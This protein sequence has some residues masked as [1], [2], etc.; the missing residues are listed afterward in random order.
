MAK[1]TSIV[2]LYIHIVII[3]L[4]SHSA[5]IKAT[6]ESS[7][8]FPP[9]SI[10]CKVWNHTNMDCSWRELDCIPLVRHKAS[11]K[12]LDM[13]HN[14]LTVLPEGAFSGFIKLKTLDLSSNGISVKNGMFIGLNMLQTLDM[15]HNF[16]EYIPDDAFS[17]LDMLQTLDVSHN[18]LQSLP[19]NVFSGLPN[20]L[21]LYLSNMDLHS[22]NNRTFNGLGKLETLDLSSGRGLV[23]YD[24]P[25]QYLSS[26]HT[27]SLCADNPWES[28]V[29]P[30]TFAGLNHTLQ[31][32]SIR[33]VDSTSD[34]PFVQ[35]SSLQ[36]LELVVTT[37]AVPEELFS[38]LDKLRHLELTMTIVFDLNSIFDF[39]PLVSLTF[40]SCHFL[41][42]SQRVLND[43]FIQPL[44]LSNSPLQTLELHIFTLA[45]VRFRFNST[46]FESLPKWKESLREL[47]IYF[48]D[49]FTD[50]QIEGSPF[51]WFSQLH[52]LRMCGDKPDVATISWHSPEDTFKGL[53]NLKEV[54]LNY[55]HIDDEL[56]DAVLSTFVMY[57]NSLEVLDLAHNYIQMLGYIVDKIS[58]I[59][60]LKAIDISHNIHRGI[61]VRPG[62]FGSFCAYNSNLSTLN[63]NNF[64]WWSDRSPFTCSSLVSLN[65]SNSVATIYN[66]G[67]VIHAPHLEELHLSGIQITTF[68][69]HKSLSAIKV[70]KF[71]DVPQLKTLDLSSSQLLIIDK[72][73][74]WRLSNV[75]YLDLRNNLLTTLS[76]LYHL[77]NVE[78]LLLSGNQ[79]P[80]VP[81]S[82]LSES[83]LQILDLQDNVFT[84]DC[85]IEGLQ[86]WVLTDDLTYLW[87]IFSKGHRYKC[88]V[89]QKSMG[90]SLTEVDLGYCDVPLFMYISVGVTSGLV[91]IIAAILVVWYRWHIQYRLFLLFNRRAYQNY[92]VNGDDADDDFE[93]EDGPP[94]Y[95]AYVIYNN[96]DEDW[97]DEQLVA[98]IE[99]N[100]EEPFRLCLKN[101]DI[102]A[103]RLI[104]NELSLHI[105]R[106]R[107]TLVILTPR[108]VD[109]NWCYF[110]LNMAHHRVL[111]E[112][113]NVLIFIM[114][115]KIPNNRLT[116]LLRQLF[117]RAQCLKWPNDERGQNLFWRCLREELKRP[118]PRDNQVIQYRQYN[119]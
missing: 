97:V 48:E 67:F 36:H 32:L 19:D 86:K 109:D 116:L 31:V 108:F 4:V 44:N 96:Q 52:L 61:E 98:N 95:D 68:W 83:T 22:V 37:Y 33:I 69:N 7:C 101:R 74:T 46:T 21:S 6:A 16:L 28:Y 87:N 91:A 60:T 112:N 57:N 62:Y 77:Y 10:A 56:A 18:W 45:T 9:G 113:H 35:L 17:G 94:R 58:E 82:F 8:S 84:C 102:R 49:T 30:A 71:L 100:H 81:K 92:L 70:L 5:D 66:S 12:L 47:K 43:A 85:N 23:L 38:G 50:L 14:N 40:L 20:L 13:S 65:A 75:T 107:K 78:V 89:P 105:R 55:L 111:E 88:G 76:T 59:P 110:Q 106:S 41:Y 24:S 11:L 114:L 79:I 34:S 54:H 39:S 51:K 3:Y 99:E 15:S 63:V 72:D 104:F 115:E 118:V 64:A 119:I 25:F 1:A 27:L 42:F 80:T 26:L 2:F 93:D 90:F 103:G 29:T 117:C 53:S 73:D